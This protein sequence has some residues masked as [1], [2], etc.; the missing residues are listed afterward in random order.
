MSQLFF[1][2]FLIFLC[3]ISHLISDMATMLHKIILLTQ[4]KIQYN[5]SMTFKQIKVM[6]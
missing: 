5:D 4:N 2:I 1:I 6:P 3:E